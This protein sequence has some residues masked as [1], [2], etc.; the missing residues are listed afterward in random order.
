MKS[1]LVS[2]SLGVYKYTHVRIHRSF[3]KTAIAK[4][5]TITWLLLTP[6][7]TYGALATMTYSLLM[8]AL[9]FSSDSGR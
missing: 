8:P 7:L 6:A 9:H 3:I 2:G 1:D 5:M 4:P